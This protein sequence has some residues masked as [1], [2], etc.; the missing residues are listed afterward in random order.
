MHA[1]W[2]AAVGLAALAIGASPALAQDDDG[3][4]HHGRHGMFSAADANA[5]G[6]L[7]RQEF[8]AAHGAH[9]AEMDANTDGQ[10]TREERR[11]GRRERGHGRHGR[12]ESHLAE[13]DANGDGS[14]TRDEFLA[15]PLAM[16]ARLDVNNDG[17]IS[18]AERPQGP[19]HGG[20]HG[21]GPDADNDGRLSRAEFD[22]R[23]AAMFDRLD[24]NDDGR[25][26]RE[27]AAAAH[28]H[29]RGRD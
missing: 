22:A 25:V 11:A 23:G 2:F 27:E 1:S 19:P 15:H 18:A 26:T 6:V 21:G 5:D 28:A 7:T 16:F 4:R 29:H 12:R 17:V 3:P 24:A 20:G 10:V 8:D 14:I 9:F 13:A